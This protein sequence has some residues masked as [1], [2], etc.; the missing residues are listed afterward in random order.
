MGPL[1]FS[2]S[3]SLSLPVS[4]SLL[5]ARSPLN[6][7][8]EEQ[9][10]LSE[11]KVTSKV[12]RIGTKKV[13]KKFSKK[14]IFGN[15]RD[16]EGKRFALLGFIL[17]G[18]FERN[19]IHLPGNAT[20]AKRAP[21]HYPICLMCFLSLSSLY[22]HS[23]FI[24]VPYPFI[25]VAYKLLSYSVSPIDPHKTKILRMGWTR[26][27]NCCFRDARLCSRD[28]KFLTIEV[29]IELLRNSHFNVWRSFHLIFHYFKEKV[30]NY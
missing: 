15:E 26:I 25:C 21:S 20:Q 23:L 7:S 27:F 6:H 24:A 22:F 4:L 2:L 14:S 8:T 17:L 12:T 18:P 29:F 30:R 19:S 5:P 1:S 11:K 13:L 9:P 10:R 16:S 28:M 3:L